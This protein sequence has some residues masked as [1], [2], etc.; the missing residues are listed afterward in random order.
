MKALYPLLITATLC[1]ITQ[2][3]HSSLILQK[4]NIPFLETEFLGEPKPER[5]LSMDEIQ[6]EV[7]KD[8]TNTDVYYGMISGM[9]ANPVD[10][11]E[12]LKELKQELLDFRKHMDSQLIPDEILERR[13]FVYITNAQ[14]QENMK[15]IVV[16]VK[17]R[18]L[19]EEQDYQGLMEQARNNQLFHIDLQ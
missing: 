10:F 3:Q 16:D 14:F 18:V 12:S 7:K 8:R 2:I 17:K 9:G 4:L 15:N 6:D 1:K 11:K 13:N 19:E 5:H